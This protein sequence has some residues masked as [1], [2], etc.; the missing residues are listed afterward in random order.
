MPPSKITT[1]SALI[2]GLIFGTGLI[3]SGMTN[4]AK[5]ISFLD[6]TG[7]WDP[8]LLLVMGSALAINVWVFRWIKTRKTSL[9]GNDIKFPL[10]QHIDISLIAGSITFGIG[11]GLSGYCP[12]PAIASIFTGS[13]KTIIFLIAMISG[14][15]IANLYKRSKKF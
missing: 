9:L 15:L 8:S 5:I 13:A 6:I 7:E 4:P 11:W 1:L 10:K 12:G 14:M 3:V 2:S